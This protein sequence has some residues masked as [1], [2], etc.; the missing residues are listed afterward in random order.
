[1]VERRNHE[2]HTANRYLGVYDQK[3]DMLLGCLVELGTDSIHII[4]KEEYR[5][6]N[7][8]RLK[9]DLHEEID[10]SRGLC[11]TAKNVSSEVQDDGVLFASSFQIHN[12]D[13]EV[14]RRISLLIESSA[15]NTNLVE[16]SG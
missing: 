8:Y 11:F 16:Q 5:I 3:T 10:N 2:R 14:E 7:V 9:L 1:M 4:G 12:I 13:H 15:F 6:G